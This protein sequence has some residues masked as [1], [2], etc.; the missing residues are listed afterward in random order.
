MEDY[1]T[2]HYNDMNEISDADAKLQ[3][4]RLHVYFKSLSKEIISEEAKFSG[5]QI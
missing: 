1:L 4:A 2:E 5:S 3:V